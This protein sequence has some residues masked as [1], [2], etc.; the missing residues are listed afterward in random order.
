MEAPMTRRGGKGPELTVRVSHE[1]NRLGPAHV[2]A[3]FERLVPVLE[4]RTRLLC[5]E[6][7]KHETDAARGGAK[8]MTDPFAIRDVTNSAMPRAG[9]RSR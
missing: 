9:V 2:A 1:A 6:A 8:L 3:A 4:R 5:A 7:D